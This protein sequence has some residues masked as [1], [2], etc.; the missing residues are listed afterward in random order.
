MADVTAL[1]ADA[2]HMLAFQA[3]DEEAFVQLYQRYRDPIFRFCFR[4]LGGQSSAEDATQEVF[5][6]LYKARRRYTA[7]AAFSTYLYRIAKNHCL[8]VLAKAERR[9]VEAMPDAEHASSG[10]SPERRAG[11]SALREDI[12]QALQKLP[13]QQSA[14]FVLV[15]YEGQSYREAADILDSSES[16]IKSLVYRARQSLLRS[17]KPW[18]AQHPGDV[19]AV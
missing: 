17:L 9:L 7:Q 12:R 2:Q 1:D 3:G 19:H 13:A 15:H 8:N 14:A 16:A 4:L 10:H 11:Q 18:I 5:V 6:K